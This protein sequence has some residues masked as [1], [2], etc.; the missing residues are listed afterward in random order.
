MKGARQTLH[1]RTWDDCVCSGHIYTVY[2]HEITWV[3]PKKTRTQVLILVFTATKLIGMI[4]S[5][6]IAYS[7]QTLPI[8]D[9]SLYVGMAVWEAGNN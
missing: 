1:N 5:H 7:A 8:G 6:V 9:T 2:L 4:C 3:I